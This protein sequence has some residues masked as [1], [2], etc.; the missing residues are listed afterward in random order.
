MATDFLAGD[1]ISIQLDCVRFVPT[2]VLRFQRYIEI[3]ATELPFIWAAFFV[4]FVVKGYAKR[5]VNDQKPLI[6]N[7]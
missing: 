4:L 1:G 2:I 5:T 7:D 6:L 3:E